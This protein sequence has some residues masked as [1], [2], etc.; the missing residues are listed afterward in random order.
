MALNIFLE[1]SVTAAILVNIPH[2]KGFLTNVDC[3]VSD[4]NASNFVTGE[5]K[6]SL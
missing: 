1:L 6:V 5:T 2:V 4:Y 3:C